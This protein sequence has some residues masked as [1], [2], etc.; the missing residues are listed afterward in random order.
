MRGRVIG[1]AI[2]AVARAEHSPAKAASGTGSAMV[3]AP[4]GFSLSVGA[5]TG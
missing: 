1:Q 2:G 5:E 3:P 4:D